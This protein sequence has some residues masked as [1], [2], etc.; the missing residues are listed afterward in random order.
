MKNLQTNDGVSVLIPTYMVSNIQ[1]ND[2]LDLLYTLSL[3]KLN[4]LSAIIIADDNGD[5][6]IWESFLNKLK[7]FNNVFKN[8]LLVKRYENNLGF[9]G[10]V[11]RL[12]NS[13]NSNISVLINNDTLVLSDFINRIYNITKKNDDNYL[14]GCILFQDGFE[15]KHVKKHQIISENIR[16][17]WLNPEGITALVGNGMFGYTKNFSHK[18]CTDF[19]IGMF[20]DDEFCIRHIKNGGQIKVIKDIIIYHKV[21]RT[22]RSI[23]DS[24]EMFDLF[25]ENKEIFTVITGLEF[26]DDGKYNI[27]DITG[28]INNEK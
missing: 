16:F 26:R 6:I 5:K 15:K 19:K 4:N 2:T 24:K 18:F 23:M 17:D 12:I 27:P 25:H 11:N 28:E 8:K 22:F 3:N 13:V 9:S 14:I 10:N 21:S 7:H 1:M 20:E